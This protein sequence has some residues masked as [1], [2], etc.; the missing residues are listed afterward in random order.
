MLYRR[1]LRTNTLLPSPTQAACIDILCSSYVFFLFP[2]T[3]IL[4]TLVFHYFKQ[5][6][7]TGDS[8]SLAHSNTLLCPTLSWIFNSL[9]KSAPRL[10]CKLA[11]IYVSSFPM[12]K[13]CTPNFVVIF[14]RFFV[15]TL[16]LLPVGR[17]YL[18]YIFW[19]LCK[20]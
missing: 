13:P 3:L 20:R 18:V 5:A 12:N 16:T 8:A 2:C 10:F 17:I 6:V 7:I 9:S 1:L 14:I 4:F 15:P 19:I 11:G